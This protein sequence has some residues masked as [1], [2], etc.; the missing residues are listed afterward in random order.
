MEKFVDSPLFMLQAPTRNK[1]GSIERC[2][3]LQAIAIN[4]LS[5]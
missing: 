3:N 1:F 2:V 5:S 4:Y